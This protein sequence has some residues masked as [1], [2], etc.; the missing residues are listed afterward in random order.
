MVESRARY[1]ALVGTTRRASLSPRPS[2][3]SREFCVYLPR[4]S[5][6]SRQV[7]KIFV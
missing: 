1:V 3:L 7:S 4:F 6:L 2:V 5:H